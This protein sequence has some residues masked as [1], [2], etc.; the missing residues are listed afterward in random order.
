MHDSDIDTSDIAESTRWSN[1]TVGRF[2]RPIKR[3]VTVRL[4]ADVVAWLKSEGEG[5]QTR[6]NKLLRAAMSQSHKSG[7]RVS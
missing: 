2:F 6:L 3:P 1:A 5:Y 4:D 7:R